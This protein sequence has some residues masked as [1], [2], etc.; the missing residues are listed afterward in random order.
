MGAQKVQLRLE[1]RLRVDGHQA[2]ERSTERSGVHTRNK[3]QLHICDDIAGD[4][5]P[6]RKTQDRFGQRVVHNAIEPKGSTVQ[7]GASRQ[8]SPTMYVSG[9][10]GTH[11][12]PKLFPEALRRYLFRHRRAA[13]RRSPEPPTAPPT[14]I[15]YSRTSGFS[16][17]SFGRAC[18][19][20]QAR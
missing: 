17:L 15:R 16:V 12:G 10:T 13:I 8:I 1:G 2:V 3:G 20:H 6:C 4:A 9:F 5:I 7:S 11:P 18:R 19:P 14:C